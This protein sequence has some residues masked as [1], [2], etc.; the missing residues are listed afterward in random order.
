[1]LF[2]I[3]VKALFILL[4]TLTAL[5]FGSTYRFVGKKVKAILEPAQE[6]GKMAISALIVKGKI[7][8]PGVVI[9]LKGSIIFH[10][11]VGQQTEVDLNDITDFKEVSYFNG[12]LLIGKKGFWFTHSEGGRLACA[13]PKSY[14]PDLRAWL[15]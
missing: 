11:I 13:I 1:M 6:A 14:A 8:S 7:E 4:F 12:S 5:I 10:P 2:F 3:G 9:L 15:S